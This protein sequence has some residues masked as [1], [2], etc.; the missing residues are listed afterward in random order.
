M[1]RK[2]KIDLS[3]TDKHY[4]TGSSM[5]EYNKKDL[6]NESANT[7]DAVLHKTHT[8]NTN[9]AFATC[10]TTSNNTLQTRRQSNTQNYVLNKKSA[11]SVSKTTISKETN[12]A[13]KECE[14]THDRVIKR[15][16]SHYHDKKRVFTNIK[17]CTQNHSIKATRDAATPAKDKKEHTKKSIS[18]L[19]NPSKKSTTMKSTPSSTITFSC[20]KEPT[21]SLVSMLANDSPLASNIKTCVNS[22]NSTNIING[23]SNGRDANKNGIMSNSHDD[24]TNNRVVGNI[25]TSSVHNTNNGRNTS[26][27]CIC[28]N[29]CIYN[30]NYIAS[31][32]HMIDNVHIASNTANTVGSLPLNKTRIPYYPKVLMKPCEHVTIPI[33]TSSNTRDMSI[34]TECPIREKH[35]MVA[36]NT[37]VSSTSERKENTINSHNDDNTKDAIHDKTF[38]PLIRECGECAE[39]KCDHYKFQMDIYE[40]QCEPQGIHSGAGILCFS[41]SPLQGEYYLLLGKEDDVLVNDMIID[42]ELSVSSPLFATSSSFC[43]NT[44]QSYNRPQVNSVDIS[45]TSDATVPHFLTN[46]IQKGDNTLPSIP[47]TNKFVNNTNTHTNA[48]K[49]VDYATSSNRQ[50]WIPTNSINKDTVHRCIPKTFSSSSNTSPLASEE[51]HGNKHDKTLKLR[52]KQGQWSDLGG[53]ASEHEKTSQETATREFH[54]ESLGLFD[55]RIIEKEEETRVDIAYNSKGEGID[56]STNRTII[57]ND[58]NMNNEQT[59]SNDVNASNKENMA[60]EKD[61]INCNNTSNRETTDNEK[62]REEII[63]NKHQELLQSLQ[64]GEYLL[65][66]VITTNHGYDIEETKRLYTIYLKQIPWQPEK[67]E[68]YNQLHLCLKQIAFHSRSFQTFVRDNVYGT[69]ATTNG[70]ATANTN[71]IT[72]ETSTVDTDTIDTNISTTTNTATTANN[73]TTA[74]TTTTITTSNNDTTITIDNHTNDTRTF[75]YTTMDSYPLPHQFYHVPNSP[76]SY[77]IKSILHLS[78]SLV[79]FQAKMF[80]DSTPLLSCIFSVALHRVIEDDESTQVAARTSLEGDTLYYRALKHYQVMND[81]YSN[82]PLKTKNHPCFRFTNIQGIPII[83][84]GDEYLEKQCIQYWNLSCLEYMLNNGGHV[85]KQNFSNASI[86]SLA[87][88]IDYFKVAS[89][90]DTTSKALTLHSNEVTKRHDGNTFASRLSNSTMQRGTLY[91]DCKNTCKQPARIHKSNPF[92]CYYLTGPKSRLF[93]QVKLVCN[94]LT[95]RHCQERDYKKDA[96]TQEY[97]KTSESK[98]IPD[99]GNNKI[100]EVHN[101]I[102]TTSNAATI[103]TNIITNATTNTVV[104]KDTLFSSVPPNKEKTF[105][106]SHKTTVKQQETMQSLSLVPQNEHEKNHTL[107]TLQEQN[108][109]KRQSVPL[110][111]CA[112]LTEYNK[113]PYCKDTITRGETRVPNI[114]NVPIQDIL[115]N[116]HTFASIPLQIKKEFIIQIL[117]E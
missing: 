19:S 67:C 115:Q 76:I 18:I 3:G 116:I 32:N 70:T 43:Y 72:S 47:K 80:I 22:V 38:K 82:L 49:H 113:R 102:N 101:H 71:T 87:M 75:A 17:K 73:T 90:R 9:G 40:A 108:T 117:P 51:G 31:D 20:T 100:N 24:V 77:H 103:N 13:I 21:E 33:K 10:N 109:C 65:K 96:L 104:R 48:N 44:R 36:A 16:T 8:R 7:R 61:T 2:A 4:R 66:L 68:E 11:K 105:L 57:S 94:C 34:K 98:C 45:T 58:D 89:T 60:N 27:T 62:N 55:L 28:N 41:L 81:M 95:P 35:D 1:T 37:R 111:K 97:N 112:S 54:E 83:D 56:I 86:A 14:S 93:G 50:S 12:H 85:R 59:I 5:E 114:V 52:K 6:F 92:Y 23:A 64:Q 84:V 79:S 74:T 30:S 107:L 88:I 99:N 26:N 78:T 25:G 53:T 39:S 15:G 29:T 91:N 106:S 110:A 42:K 63:T 46:K 69:I